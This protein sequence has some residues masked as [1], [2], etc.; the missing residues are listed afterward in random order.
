[1]PRSSGEF[2]SRDGEIEVM[3]QHQNSVNSGG[4]QACASHSSSVSADGVNGGAHAANGDDAAIPQS[5]KGA[6]EHLRPVIRKRQNSEVCVSFSFRYIY[7]LNVSFSVHILT[8]L[9][10]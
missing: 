1:M 3:Q 2:V 8:L 9:C 6:P 4:V 10:T 5:V 7:I